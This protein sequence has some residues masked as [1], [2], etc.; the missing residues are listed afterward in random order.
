MPPPEERE[1]QRRPPY[2]HHRYLRRRHS[3]S[4]VEYWS[5]RVAPSRGRGALLSLVVWL[6]LM[7]RVC[8]GECPEGCDCKWKYGKDTVDCRSAGFID[9]PPTFDPGTQMLDMSH[10]NLQVLP[11][12]TFLN[13]GLLNLQRIHLQHC[14]LKQIDQEAFRRL[15]NLVELDISHNDLTYVPAAAFGEMP[16]LRRLIFNDNP[17]RR[18][19]EDAFA[20]LPSL[21]V[22]ELSRCQLERVAENAFRGLHNLTF[23]KLDGNKLMD[24]P[25]SAF[26]SL[27]SLHGIDLHDNPWHCDCRLRPARQWVLKANVPLS[28]VPVCAAPRRLAN[29]T[30]DKLGLEDFA[31]ETQ[32]TVV[33]SPFLV[34]EDDNVTLTCRVSAN[35]EPNIYWV[36]KERVIANLSAMA[37]DSKQIYIIHEDGVL[38][39]ASNLTITAVRKEDAGVYTCVAENKA[40]TKMRNV[41]LVVAANVSLDASFTLSQVSGMVGGGAIGVVALI[42]LAC[43]LAFLYRR[44]RRERKRVLAEHKHHHV[45]L[46]NHKESALLTID[47]QSLS[48]LMAAKSTAAPRI[49]QK[50]HEIPT[51]DKYEHVTFANKNSIQGEMTKLST[52]I[53]ES[54]VIDSKGVSENNDGEEGGRAGA[55]ADNTSNEES[56]SILDQDDI[57]QNEQEH[58]KESENERSTRT[59]TSQPESCASCG[60]PLPQGRSSLDRRQRTADWAATTSGT[61]RRTTSSSDDSDAGRTRVSHHGPPHPRLKRKPISVIGVGG[62]D[63]KKQS[64]STTKV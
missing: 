58:E 44:R 60:Q 25:A 33:E 26:T 46:L 1:H 10:N 3:S 15:S 30:W 47:K 20:H 13:A 18:L 35:P 37:R 41:T 57:A 61:S 17:L 24:V 52:V 55:G 5:V 8:L 53:E 39:K 12:D 22:L 14:H 32:I 19:A 6:S 59:P 23:L 11:K 2:H 7:H 63:E 54:V 56:D 49:S 50:Y 31:C 45:C 64:E 62:D 43:C 28:V 40:N 21:T 16:A 51:V 27:R 42:V 34:D 36:W 38:D 9:V 29:Q 48:T 4:G